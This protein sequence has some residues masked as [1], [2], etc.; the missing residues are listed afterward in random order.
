MRAQQTDFK[1]AG[2]GVSLFVSWDFWI[3]KVGC[4][5]A[6]RMMP[7]SAFKVLK[8]DAFASRWLGVS[9]YHVKAIDKQMLVEEIQRLQANSY[10]IDA[11]LRP[12]DTLRPALAEQLQFIQVCTQLTFELEV[13]R[14]YDVPKHSVTEKKVNLS[15]S[16]LEAHAQNF[17]YSRW[18]QDHRILGNA[19]QRFMTEWIR[20][21]TSGKRQLVADGPNFISYDW[22]K[23]GTVVIDLVSV[24]DQGR[25]VGQRLLKQLVEDGAAQGASKI[26]VTTEAENLPAVRLYEKCGF[27]ICNS[28]LC[29]HRMHTA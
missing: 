21:S 29:F 15:V 2:R 12:D 1:F 25:G 20:N 3:A 8:S 13:K 23:T 17:P 11:K 24:L 5:V 14:S 7:N 27:R 22:V 28:T 6:E 16:H 9:V 18:S 19:K 4:K 26:L 10:F